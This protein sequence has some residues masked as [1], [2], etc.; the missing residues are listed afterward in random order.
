MLTPFIV[1][2]A[3]LQVE[4]DKALSDSKAAALSV[5]EAK[6]AMADMEEKLSDSQLETKMVMEELADATQLA[7][8]MKEQLYGAHKQLEDVEV[9]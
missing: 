8:V 5:A 1:P 4:Q 9:R 7:E 6:S 3:K 2:K